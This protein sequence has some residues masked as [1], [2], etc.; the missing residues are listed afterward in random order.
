VPQYPGGS[1]SVHINTQTVHSTTQWEHRTTQWE[2]GTTQW[3]N[4]YLVEHV[5]AYLAIMGYYKLKKHFE[6][7]N[8]VRTV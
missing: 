4:H 2:H 6:G 3:A 7:N 5:S 1:S 8:I